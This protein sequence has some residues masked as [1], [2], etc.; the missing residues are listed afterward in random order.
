M[1]GSGC[2]AVLAFLAR[3]LLLTYPIGR[4]RHGRR[5]AKQDRI[6]L[7]YGLTWLIW[8]ERNAHVCERKTTSARALCTAIAD[9]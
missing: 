7:Q 4:L 3:R 6:I 8:K 2:E 5:L 9:E 1:C